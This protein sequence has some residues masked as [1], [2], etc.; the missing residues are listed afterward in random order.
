VLKQSC[1]LFAYVVLRLCREYFEP[2]GWPCVAFVV[3][4]LQTHS[5]E[6]GGAGA[7]AGWKLRFAWWMFI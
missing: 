3:P 4:V 6:G 5:N 2:I 1:C 7:C